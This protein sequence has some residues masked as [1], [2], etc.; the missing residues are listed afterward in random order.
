[1]DI[2]GILL[3]CSRAARFALPLGAVWLAL[4]IGVQV[5]LGRKIAWGRELLLLATVVYFA[6]L[7]QITVWRSG[8]NLREALVSCQ[9]LPTQMELLK[10]TRSQLRAGWRWGL[11]HIGGNLCWFV[12]MGVLLPLLNR[13]WSFGGTVLAGMLLSISIETLQWLLRTGVT[14]IDDVLFNTLGAALGWILCAGGRALH[15][16]ISRR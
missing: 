14:D 10:T 16:N 6:A 15:K 1:M 13:R 12:P 3:Y 11:Y 8:V 4:R 5:A 9:R 7:L 2:S